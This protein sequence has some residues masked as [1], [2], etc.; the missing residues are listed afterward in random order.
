MSGIVLLLRSFNL[1]YALP[2]PTTTETTESRRPIGHKVAGAEYYDY[3]DEYDKHSII[4]TEGGG[5]AGDGSNGSGGNSSGGSG[6]SSGNQGNGGTGNSSGGVGGGNVGTN[7]GGTGTGSNGLATGAGSSANTGSN[8]G[9]G[10]G[11]GSGYDG[12]AALRSLRQ[13]IEESRAESYARLLETAEDK[14]KAMESIRERE[15]IQESIKKEM[16]KESIMQ[17]FYGETY[18]KESVVPTE[19]NKSYEE[20]N[21][22][23]ETETT[24]KNTNN[25][26]WF[27]DIVDLF[28]P[29]ESTKQPQAVDQ[30]IEAPTHQFDRS[31]IYDDNNN[32]MPSESETQRYD[33]TEDIQM[34]E[35]VITNSFSETLSASAQQNAQY[36]RPIEPQDFIK[37]T[38]KETKAKEETKETL[39]PTADPN[40]TTKEVT[41]EATQAEET[42]D[43]PET[44]ETI[45]EEG[46][47][48]TKPEENEGAE[49]GNE[50]EEEP[51]KAG[52]DNKDNQDSDDNGGGSGQGTTDG[53]QKGV[54]IFEIDAIGGIGA[55]ES[56]VHIDLM[57]IIMN[58][59]LIICFI[60][61][62]VFYY[63]DIGYKR[64]LKKGYF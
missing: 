53:K 6:T 47:G 57:K 48:E 15:S 35:A 29:P 49:G 22:P 25:A 28:I 13:A 60:S 9:S 39:E 59:I 62:F 5:G 16:A 36:V 38:S 3:L 56:A 4:I 32:I 45:E 12:A 24:A 18:V 26:R 40:E 51:D 44:Q 8:A 55:G 1:T 33:F 37:E 58:L 7:F 52:T 42:K 10:G 30:T 20:N 31:N 61:G 34:Q 19:A 46:R 63:A 2:T 50:R 43:I 41:S 64:E 54:K 11:T 27:F 21:G 14:N 23:P 17:K